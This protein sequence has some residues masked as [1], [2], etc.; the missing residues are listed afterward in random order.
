MVARLGL[1]RCAWR[2]G[3]Q[4]SPANGM[5]AIALLHCHRRGTP[6]CPNFS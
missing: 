6:Q 4:K 5:V 2:Q 1:P 3:I